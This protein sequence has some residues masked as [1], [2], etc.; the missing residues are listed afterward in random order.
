MHLIG[1]NSKKNPPPLSPE[2]YTPIYICIYITDFIFYKKKL[3]NN[4]NK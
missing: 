4:N 1:V 3:L 2:P